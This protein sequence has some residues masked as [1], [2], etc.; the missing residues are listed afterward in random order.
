MSLRKQWLT[1]NWWNCVNG[2]FDFV[3][4]VNASRIHAN[5]GTTGSNAYR[6]SQYVIYRFRLYY[7]LAKQSKISLIWSQDNFTVPTDPKFL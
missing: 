7:T 1:V 2:S 6:K 3:H 5:L 4:K